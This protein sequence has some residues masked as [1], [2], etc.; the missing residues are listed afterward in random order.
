MPFG[1][2]NASLENCVDE[3]IE[4][5]D[6]VALTEDLPKHRLLC[7][8]TGAVVL[9][10]APGVFEVEFIDRSGFTLA[11]LTLPQEKLVLTWK[12]GQVK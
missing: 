6:V 10:H 5:Y 1:V 8:Q 12:Y 4:M 9:V 3:N 11:L 7:G 2:Y